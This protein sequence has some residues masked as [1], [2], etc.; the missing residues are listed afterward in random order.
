M[1]AVAVGCAFNARTPQASDATL[2]QKLTSLVPVDLLPS[3]YTLSYEGS[4]TASAGPSEMALVLSFK[5]PIGDRVT[6]SI[7]RAESK[8]VA[9]TKFKERTYALAQLPIQGFVEP[10]PSSTVRLVTP[11][12]TALPADAEQSCALRE[13]H[14]YAVGEVARSFRSVNLRYGQAVTFD[15]FVRDTVLVTLE[16]E[17]AEES[18]LDRGTLLHQLD[19]KIRGK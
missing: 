1:V 2:T 9:L 17:T 6:F 4:E 14:P 11:C 3:D 8:G 10:V 16:T 7:V 19:I 13:V 12:T 5:S 15:V 18:T